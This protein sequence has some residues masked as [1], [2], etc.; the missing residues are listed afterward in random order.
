MQ[1]GTDGGI[2]AAG[3]RCARTGFPHTVRVTRAATPGYSSYRTTIALPVLASALVCRILQFAAPWRAVPPVLQGARPCPVGMPHIPARCTMHLRQHI[4]KR[5]LGSFHTRWSPSNVARAYCNSP[6]SCRPVPTECGGTPALGAKLDRDGI[7]PAGQALQSPTFLFAVFRTAPS[8][9]SV[10]QARGALCLVVE[11]ALKRPA[12]HSLRVLYSSPEFRMDRSA[13]AACSPPCVAKVRGHSGSRPQ[14]WPLVHCGMLDR[15]HAVTTV[16]S[17]SLSAPLGVLTNVRDENRPL[18]NFA[19][20]RTR[21]PPYAR[22]GR[23]GGRAIRFRQCPPPP[24]AYR[25]GRPHSVPY[26][27]RQH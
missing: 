4:V 15:P 12:G 26:R 24:C 19:A 13:P 14:T 6:E 1:T 18:D 17:S 7:S 2:F 3:A 11:S 10:G 23:R 16:R 9:I 27:R 5:L 8:N 22:I 21:R 25:R 20:A